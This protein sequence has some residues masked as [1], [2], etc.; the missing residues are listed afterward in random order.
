MQRLA[1]HVVDQSGKS[2]PI[3]VVTISLGGEIRE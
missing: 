3:E 1:E 2:I